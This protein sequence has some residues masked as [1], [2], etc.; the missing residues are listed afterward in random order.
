MKSIEEE[1]KG[2]ICS[3]YMNFYDSLMELDKEDIVGK[4]WE[5]HF[6]QY[7]FGYLM[8]DDVLDE[9]TKKSL[10]K[11]DNILESLNQ[12][13]NDAEYAPYTFEDMAQDLIYEQLKETEAEQE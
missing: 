12:K 9:K 8:N 3:E 10:L 5:I 2:K 1:F 7:M 13:Y 11:V 4:A 6:K